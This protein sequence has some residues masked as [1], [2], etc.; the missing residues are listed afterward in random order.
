MWSI[1]GRSAFKN[2]AQ[3]RLKA[4][5]AQGGRIERWFYESSLTSDRPMT[6]IASTDIRKSLPPPLNPRPWI[7]TALSQPTL[8]L[9]RQLPQ[10]R[11]ALPRIACKG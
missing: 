10:K 11:D 3:S 8:G 1:Q 5:A 9:G 7:S 2:A 4:V 6:G